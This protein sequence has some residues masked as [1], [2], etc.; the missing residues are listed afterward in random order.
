MMKTEAYEEQRLAAYLAAV[1]GIVG[2][3]ADDEERAE[4]RRWFRLGAPAAHAAVSVKASRLVAKPAPS[5]A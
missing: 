2:S 4:A 1:E 3:P 5:S